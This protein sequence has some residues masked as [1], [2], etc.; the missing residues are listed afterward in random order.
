MTKITSVGVIVRN[1]DDTARDTL[2]ELLH[3]LDARKTKV[4]CDRSVQ[5]LTSD[6][7]IYTIEEIGTQVEACI[8]IGGDGTLLGAA[9]KLVDY[10]VPLI[11]INRG[12]LGFLVDINPEE[13]FQHLSEILDGRYEAEERFMV[14]CLVMRKG[15][16]I[17]SYNA[18]NDIVVRLGDRLRVLEYETYIDDRF[19]Y[20]QR[21]DGLII[22]TPTGSTA[23]ALSN[24]GPIIHP[25]QDALLLVSISPHTLSSRPL[26]VSRNSE[27]RV[28]LNHLDD[29]GA[30]LIADGQDYH[31]LQNGDHI[32]T[33]SQT[34]PVVL[35]HPQSYDFFEIL[36]AKLNWG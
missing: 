23:Y 26:V 5:A 21:A 17:A 3:W 12:R 2:I 28:E 9:R 6:Y 24:G 14:E 22:A 30:Q 31:V 11:G 25:A 27:I 8:V 20:L 33:K 18:L 32:V 36:R 7:P 10:R 15:V 4:F 1:I 16:A 35:L 19:V 13:Q 29:E 34:Q